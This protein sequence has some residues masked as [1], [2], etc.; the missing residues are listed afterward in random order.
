MLDPA[1][2]L[3]PEEALKHPYLR[4]PMYPASTLQHV[5]VASNHSVTAPT[6]NTIG[7]MKQSVPTVLSNDG[8]KNAFSTQCQPKDEK[9]D[10]IEPLHI[11]LPA[12]NP[13]SSSPDAKQAINLDATSVAPSVKSALATSAVS[14]E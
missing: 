8:A 4:E 13:K 14:S 12:A 1:K 11:S 7:S 2:R 3:T 5:K 6:I 10:T 9:S